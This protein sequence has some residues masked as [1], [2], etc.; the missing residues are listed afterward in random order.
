MGCQPR[1]ISR[2][3]D[4]R[5][6][7][8]DLLKETGAS[9]IALARPR[10][11]QQNAGSATAREAAASPSTPAAGVAPIGS[12]SI[13]GS[14]VGIGVSH[15]G[16]AIAEEG[17]LL[18]SSSEYFPDASVV[19]GVEVVSNGQQ[20][21]G[22]RALYSGWEENGGGGDGGG[23]EGSTTSSKIPKAVVARTNAAFRS[24][25]AVGGENT[26]N[27]S[28]SISSDTIGTAGPS[29]A[30]GGDNT[31]KSSSSGGCAS[32]GRVSSSQCFGEDDESAIKSAESL[33][34]HYANLTATATSKKLRVI[35]AAMR[36]MP[37]SLFALSVLEDD[38]S[39]YKASRG[40][41]Y[42]KGQD[43]P[44]SS[45]SSTMLAT[46]RYTSSLS[47]ATDGVGRISGK[48]WVWPDLT[49]DA[50]PSDCEERDGRVSSSSSKEKNVQVREREPM[51]GG[52]LVEATRKIPAE[53]AGLANAIN[54]TTV[55]AGPAPP[56]SSAV[57]KYG[58]SSRRE[59]NREYLKHSWRKSDIGRAASE[60]S[61]RV[62]N[63]ASHDDDI[64]DSSSSRSRSEAVASP[65]ELPEISMTD[66]AAGYPGSNEAVQKTRSREEDE[67]VV[68]G[69]SK[70]GI[71]D[72]DASA[73]A[74]APSSSSSSSS[75]STSGF[76]G[77]LARVAGTPT[78]DAIGGDIHL[79][80]VVAGKRSL[81]R[82][83]HF[84][85]LVRA[86]GL[87]GFE[88]HRL[89]GWYGKRV[90]S[91]LLSLLAH[92]RLGELHKSGGKHK[93]S[94]TREGHF[95][96]GALLIR[97]LHH[98]LFLLARTFPSCLLCWSYLKQKSYS[99]EDIPLLLI[100]ARGGGGLEGAEKVFSFVSHI[101]YYGPLFCLFH[102]GG[103]VAHVGRPLCC[104]F[105]L[106]FLGEK[107]RFMTNL[108]GFRK[109]PS[110]VRRLFVWSVGKLFG[111]SLG[112]FVCLC[113]CLS[114]GWIVVV[115]SK[116]WAK[117]H[118]L[119]TTIR[120]LVCD[121][122]DSLVLPTQKTDPRRLQREEITF[123]P[124]AVVPGRT[125]VLG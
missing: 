26:N 58:G 66:T 119:G 7:V 11:T 98:L 37:A 59:Q 21:G 65:V 110:S 32:G 27:N 24:N 102:E 105:F 60:R 18:P 73:D 2:G 20:N 31:K 103:Y 87:M 61:Q 76:G 10:A 30:K 51:G 122:R 13:L 108:W 67:A 81:T 89:K 93:N 15:G 69:G 38:S 52:A 42:G 41:I 97:Q 28:S 22:D 118:P 99:H 71:G 47:D 9:I 101:F 3:F 115:F 74:S 6:S 43:A 53:E 35:P 109:D 123:R 12:T 40:S 56:E 111:P 36:V 33:E 112:W 120:R 17:K 5:L 96:S 113:I 25:Q 72:A 55:V 106:S 48:E 34:E 83:L 82:L 46:G 77:E 63:V 94:V 29:Q 84:V 121:L 88:G 124:T 92:W 91:L 44:L 50:S 95:F 86:E 78:V 114:V 45:S 116:C 90:L 54:T 62:R 14:S 19:P 75:S 117:R 85:D 57:L 104:F 125:Y 68:V 79:V 107:E 64:S 70:P 100:C 4:S 80:A 49:A 1:R 16:G 39:M 8:A 23:M